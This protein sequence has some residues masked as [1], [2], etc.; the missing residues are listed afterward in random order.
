MIFH[1]EYP[2]QK[3]LNATSQAH[4]KLQFVNVFLVGISKY[5]LFPN[6]QDS[7]ISTRNYEKHEIL[8]LWKWQNFNKAN[9]L[10][11]EQW[12]KSYENSTIRKANGPGG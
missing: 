11:T 12:R 3:L 9:N 8:L 1:C 6:F 5:I 4:Q 7:D 10:E 2:E